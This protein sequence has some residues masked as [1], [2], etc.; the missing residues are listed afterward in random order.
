MF[1][2]ISYRLTLKPVTIFDETSLWSFS[3]LKIPL[4]RNK[5][6]VKV[7]LIA[8]LSFLSVDSDLQKHWISSRVAII[9][10]SWPL[11]LYGSNYLTTLLYFFAMFSENNNLI[12][13]HLLEKVESGK[14]LD[15]QCK[16]RRIEFRCWSCTNSLFYMKI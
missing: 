14:Y 11:I 3:P 7:Y 12:K 4:K 2:A 1:I 10:Q 9:I 5:R 13:E 15:F 8:L 6:A 16:S